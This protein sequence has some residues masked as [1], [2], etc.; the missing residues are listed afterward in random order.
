MK[1]CLIAVKLLFMP[2]FIPVAAGTR[3]PAAACSNTQLGSSSQLEGHISTPGQHALQR[4]FL[5]SPSEWY[6]DWNLLARSLTPT[7]NQTLSSAHTDPRHT[8]SIILCVWSIR[9]HLVSSKPP[10]EP[11]FKAFGWWYIHSTT[12]PNTF[13]PPNSQKDSFR[14]FTS[15]LSHDYSV[16]LLE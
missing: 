11:E 5:G 16:F 6:K 8:D 15:Y 14:I 12:L 13:M 2:S 1:P 9:Q 4:S 3:S 10:V 7:G